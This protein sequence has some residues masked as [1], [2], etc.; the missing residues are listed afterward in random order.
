MSID[1]KEGE[2]NSNIP[3]SNSAQHAYQKSL[4]LQ[5]NQINDIL[6]PQNAD[7]DSKDKRETKKR[8]KK[9]STAC[10]YC[11]R[12]HMICDD[13]RPCNRCVKR[14]IG[15]LCHDEPPKLRKGKSPIESPIQTPI[16]VTTEISAYSSNKNLNET[17]YF[18]TNNKIPP[19]SAVLLNQTEETSHEDFNKKSID[20]N[21]NFIQ[22][23]NKNSISQLPF[24]YSEHAGSEFN[25]LTE[26]L[27]MIDDNDLINSISMT[28][29]PML[30][31]LEAT[32]L[33]RL[34]NLNIPTD[35]QTP[36][37][38]KPSNQMGA[39]SM[40][41]E[42]QYQFQQQINIQHQK[43]LQQQ[44]QQ[45]QQTQPQTQPQATFKGINQSYSSP[46]SKLS[47]LAQSAIHSNAI[48]NANPIQT[49]NLSSI[50]NLSGTITTSNPPYVSDAARDKFFLTAADPTTEISPE[51]RLKQVINAKL[52][53]G[54]LKP[55][56]YA[57]GYQRLQAYMDTHMA[58][59][60]RSRILKPLST[61]RPGFRAIAKTLKDLDLILV[62]E[63]FERMLLD[64]DRVFTSMAIPACLWRRTGEIYRGNKEFASLVEVN[65]DDLKNGKLT[66]YELMTEESSVNFWEKYGAIAFD[67][68]QKAVLTSCNLRTKDGRRK[69]NCCFSFT[70]RRDRYNIPSAIV[71][72]FIPVQ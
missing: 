24:F 57:K 52:E 26:F 16:P 45:Q 34:S 54:L 41:D 14:G 43:L 50:S 20:E 33:T 63:N 29:D 65:I 56:N 13:A 71:G 49:S 38:N 9:V 12:S 11:R 2:E 6:K 27:S 10:V 23:Q 72:N 51:E 30:K 22:F 55:Y 32:S 42:R 1:S 19:P 70:I 17:S 31:T 68:T 67:K 58:P 35:T 48:G 5:T 46:T 15:H 18:P 28:N 3:I 62:E 39:N 8:R 60:S 36:A 59:S 64:Y 44:Q 21:M 25:S 53:A 7:S 4:E 40:N 66:I 69:K 61:F 47:T 37:Y